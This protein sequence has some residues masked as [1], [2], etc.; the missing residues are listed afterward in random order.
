MAG[1]VAASDVQESPESTENALKLES[2]SAYGFAVSCSECK[3]FIA[4][5]SGGRFMCMSKTFF[6]E[7]KEFCYACVGKRAHS[8]HALVHIF[9][10]AAQLPEWKNNCLEM[11]EFRRFNGEN[12]MITLRIGNPTKP[13]KEKLKHEMRWFQLKNE[14]YK[15][16][17]NL[18][19]LRGCPE[20]P[21]AQVTFD[22]EHFET[23]QRQKMSVDRVKKYS[24]SYPENG[25]FTSE[26]ERTIASY[27]FWE[28][29]GRYVDNEDQTRCIQWAAADGTVDEILLKDARKLLDTSFGRE[30]EWK[31]R[32]IEANSRS[33]LGFHMA[34]K[35]EYLEKHPKLDEKYFDSAIYE[36]P[37]ALIE[38][39]HEIKEDA[40]KTFKIF[41]L[42]DHVCRLIER[43]ETMAKGTASLDRESDAVFDEVQKNS[44]EAFL[45]PI[46]GSLSDYISDTIRKQ[47]LLVQDHMRGRGEIDECNFSAELNAV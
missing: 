24:E 46:E 30:E 15:H 34:N 39:L 41:D 6:C 14:L 8:H 7:G 38:A 27:E 5:S 22:Q 23:M 9:D 16:A 44:E 35:A 25:R 47:A 4:P 12:S 1:V 18:W 10:G 33:I 19:R 21:Q 13:P 36:T 40:L 43:V 42:L 31:E 26:L 32:T 29:K 11:K 3:I 37:E 2:E 28:R 20:K 17:G 45:Q